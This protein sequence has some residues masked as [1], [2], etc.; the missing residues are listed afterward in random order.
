MKIQKQYFLALLLLMAALTLCSCAKKSYGSGIVQRRMG[1]GTKA[2]EAEEQIELTGRT[3]APAE[4]E[5]VSVSNLYILLKIDPAMKTAD[6]QKAGNGRLVQ[7]TYNTGTRF[8]NKYGDMKSIESFQAGD[9]AKLEI[10]SE[11]QQ[12]LSVQLSD[13]VWVY[14]D[15]VNYSID[16]SIHAVTI[17]QTRYSYDPEMGVFSGE[18]RIGIDGIGDSDILRAVGTGNK[19]ISLAVTKGHGYLALAN[20]KLF[21]GSFICV[22]DKIFQEVTKNMQIEAPEGTYLVTVANDGYGGSREVVIE[23]DKTTSLNLDEL[24]GEGPKICKIKFDVSVED[25]VLLIDGKKADYSKPVEVRYGVHTITVE[26]EGYEPITEKLVVNSAEAEMEIALTSQSGD[27]DSNKKTEEN[28]NNTNTNNGSAGT[29]NNGT[30]QN[31]TGQNGTNNN[32]GSNN[33]SGTGNT[34]QTDYLTTLYNLLTSI[35]NTGNTDS[36][37]NQS[38]GN[39]SNSSGSYDDLRDQ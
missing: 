22:G 7:Y 10:S 36:N 16:E 3:E 35:N 38:S 21:E 19:L 13:E 18:T 30:N 1:S 2:E 12:L 6:F 33:A 20:T 26:A 29:G 31:N 23:R 9:V 37:S 14:D 17:G 4:A 28:T 11:E 5:E 32:G 27:S 15:I 39:D 8:L 34:S 25:A 24:K